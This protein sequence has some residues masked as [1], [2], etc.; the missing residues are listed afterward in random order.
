MLRDVSSLRFFRRNSGKNA[1]PE[2]DENK[3][4]NSIDPSPSSLVQEASRPPLNVIQETCQLPKSASDQE[5]THRTKIERT[6]S[7][8]KAKSSLEPHAPFTT[9]DKHG[10]SSIQGRNRFGWASKNELVNGR[11]S[12]APLEKRNEVKDEVHSNQGSAGYIEGSHGLTQLPPSNRGASSVLSTPHSTRTLGKWGSCNSSESGSTQS[13][14]AKSGS[15]ATNQGVGYRPPVGVSLRAGNAALMS[16]GLS[17]AMSSP[18]PSVINTIEVPHFELR[19]DISFWM[20]HNVQVLIRI[21]PLNSME[22]SLHGFNRCL[23]QESAQTITWIGQPETRFTFDHVACETINQEMLFRVAG[24]PMVENCMSGYNSCMFAYGQTGSGKTYTMLGD[25][26]EVDVK[27]N[28]DRGMTPRIFEFLFERTRAEEESRKNEKLRYACKCSF[29]EIYNEQITDLLEPSSTNLLLR[30]DMLKGVYVENLTEYEVNTV[31]DVL[32]LLVQGAANR[33]VAATNMNRESSRSHS[34]FTCVIESR[35]EKDSMTNYRYGRLN[36]VDLAGSERQKTSGAEG[37]RLKEAANINKSLSTLGHVIMALVDVAHGKQRHVPYR[38]S[39]LTFLLQDSLG[40][41]SKTMIIANVSPSIGCANETFSTLKFAQRAKLIQNNAVVNE[42]ASGDVTA[43]QH[44]IKLLKDE[45]AL[46]KRQNVSRSLKFGEGSD[47]FTKRLPETIHSKVDD[48]HSFVAFGSPTVSTKKLK[49]LEATLTGALRREQMA[50]N[51]TKQLEA[52]IEQLNRL[53]R[54]REEESRGSKMMLRFRE[55]K[56]RRMEMLVDE[57]IPADSYLQEENNALNE[58]IQLLRTRVDRNPEIT[59]FAMENIRLLEQLRRFQDFYQEGERDILLAEISHLRNQLL[60]ILDEKC[61]QT[62][63]CEQDKDHNSYSTSQGAVQSE[64][65][66]TAQENEL[67]HLEV[68]STLKELEDCKNRL[69]SCLE[70]NE[71]LTTEMRNMQLQL[72]ELKCT[73]SNYESEIKTLQGQSL[74]ATSGGEAADVD[75]IKTVITIEQIQDPLQGLQPLLSQEAEKHML[76]ENDGQLENKVS[77]KYSEELLNLQLELNW[78]K[79]ILEEERL[80]RACVEERASHLSNELKDAKSLAEALES[81]DILS[82]NELE[83]LREANMKYSELLQR[84][85]DEI[86]LL[87][88]QIGPSLGTKEDVPLQKLE[89]WKHVSNKDSPL[90]EKLKQMQ[91]ALEKS[92]KLNM[93]YQND[94]VSHTTHEQEMDRIRQQVEAETAEAIIC[95]QEELATLQLQV[96]TSNEKEVEANRNLVALEKEF[97]ILQGRLEMVIQENS[98]LLELVAG[99]EDDIKALNN[100]WERS[101]FELSEFLADGYG[102]LDDASNQANC[103]SDSFPKGNSRIGQEFERLVRTIVE[104]DECIEDLHK[105]LGDAHTTAHDL[106]WKLRSLRGAAMAMADAQQLETTEKEREIF[107][108]QSQL[109]EKISLVSEL[110]DQIE[111][112]KAQ[113][114]KAEVCAAV[115]FLTVNRL[116]ET[117]LVQLEHLRTKKDKIICDQ[118]TEINELRNKIIEMRLQMNLL[119]ESSFDLKNSLDSSLGHVQ[120]MELQKD[121]LLTGIDILKSELKDMELQVENAWERAFSSEAIMCLTIGANQDH[122]SGCLTKVLD[123]LQS[124]EILLTNERLGQFRMGVDN[125][126]SCMNGFLGQVENPVK[127]QTRLK[128]LNGDVVAASCGLVKSEEWTKAVLAHDNGEKALWTEEERDL[129]GRA[130]Y[131][132][133]D[134]I[135]GIYFGISAGT[136]TETTAHL[137]LNKDLCSGM[138]EVEDPSTF[139]KKMREVKDMERRSNSCPKDMAIQL[140]RQEIESA[141]GSLKEVQA[142]MSVIIH[143]NKE[144]KKSEEESSGKIKA[145]ASEILKLQAEVSC[146]EEWLQLAVSKMSHR[147]YRVQ[148]RVEESKAHWY[149]SKEVLSMELSD[150]KVNAAQK[151]DEASVLLSKFQEAQETM[152]E[153]DLMVNALMKVKETAKLE[154]QGYKERECEF[155][156]ERATLVDELQDLKS[157][158]Q[159]FEFLHEHCSLNLEEIRSVFLSVE[160]LFVQVK[161]V[162]KGK[163]QAI[164]NDISELRFGLLNS[165]NLSKSWLEDIWSEI[166]G[167]DCAVSV[168][169]LCHMGI[170]LQT[171]T[172]LNAEIGFINHGLCE[173]NSLVANLR[174]LNLKAK[175]ELETCSILRGKLL[176]DIKNSFDRIIRK[177]DE[178]GKISAKLSSFEQKILDLQ[179]Q[180]E[181]M[182]AKSNAMGSELA[183]LIKELDEHERH[184]LVEQETLKREKEEAHRKLEEQERLMTEKDEGHHKLEDDSKRLQELIQVQHDWFK[185]S[186]RK[187]LD[188]FGDDSLSEFN[189]GIKDIQGGKL[190]IACYKKL[191]ERDIEILMTELVARDIEVTYLASE[192]VEGNALSFNILTELDQV[193]KEKDCLYLQVQDS[194][195]HISKVEEEVKSVKIVLQDEKQKLQ[196][197]IE[198]KN[199]EIVKIQG[200][201]AEK[202]RELVIQNDKICTARTEFDKIKRELTEV[203][204]DRGRV[205]A[206]VR[207]LKAENT[208]IFEDLKSQHD[209]T[210]SSSIQMSVLDQKNQK[211]RDE[212]C[213]LR[214]LISGLQTDLEKKITELMELNCSNSAIAKEFAT[215]SQAMATQ[216]GIINSLKIENQRLKQELGEVKEVGERMSIEGQNFRIEHARVVESLK[217]REVEMDNLLLTKHETCESLA[218][219]RRQ[220]YEILSKLHGIDNMFS[221]LSMLTEH[222]SDT[223]EAVDALCN[224]LL[225]LEGESLSCILLEEREG[226]KF[227]LADKLLQHLCDCEETAQNF[228]EESDSLEASAKKL[229]SENLSLSAELARK[230]E[231]VQGLLFDMHLLQELASNAKDRNNEI[232]EMLQVLESTE[233]E[234]EAA[235][236]RNQMFEIQLAE[237]VDS[238]SGLEMELANTQES[239]KLVSDENLS[240]NNDIKVFLTKKQSIEAELEEK[241]KLIEGL[242]EE[243]V[244]I[245]SFLDHDK[246]LI[247][248]FKNDLAKVGSE[249]D[250][251]EAEV[252]ALKDQLEMAQALAEENEAIAAEERQI[253]EAQKAYAEEKEEEV[254]LLERSVEE[255]ERTINVLE[256][257]VEI[258]IG[259]AERQRLQRE[260]LELELQAVKHQMLNVQ[261]VDMD[262]LS[263]SREVENGMA[264]HLGKKEIKLQEAQKK[265]SILEKDIFEKEAEIDKCKAH[266]TELTLHAEAQANE[267][268]QKFKALEAMAQQVK[269]ETSTSQVMPAMSARTERSASK[270]R[271]SGSPFKCIGLGLSHQINSEKDEEL[272]AGR[273]R[274][275]ELEALAASRQKEIFMLNTRLASAESMTHD[276]IRDL[277]GVKLDMTNYVSFLDH[278]HVLEISE[279]VRCQ[280]DE[281]QEKGAEVLKLRKQLNEF[282]EERAGWLDEVN[283][284]HSEMVAARIT[285]EKL[286]QHEQYLTT[287]NE[288]LKVDNT[289]HKKKVMALELEVKKLLGQQNLQQRIHH[290]AKIKEENDN[291]KV[292]NEEIADK[293]RHTEGLLSRVS[294][295]LACYRASNG[296]SPYFDLDEEER[297][298]NKLKETE[299][300]RL[301]LAQ[302]LLCLCTSILKAAGITHPTQDINPYV[303]EDAL[304]KLKDQV[305]SAERELQDLKFKNK[306]AGERIHLSG[307]RPQ[308]SP[309]NSKPSEL[310]IS[311]PIHN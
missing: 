142:Q 192:M 299:D 79:G 302:K 164:T 98:R 280:S 266:I 145:F 305:S 182:L 229:V 293:L 37:E 7:K 132:D 93:R 298:K 234:L 91:L 62:G 206:E 26:D 154:L 64:L 204:E 86:S 25:I 107:Q 116:S 4:G 92:R 1:Q 258:I 24:L 36:L 101:T 151:A 20:D 47:S 260:E 38:D 221:S 222:C 211:L 245:N 127:R 70:V 187:E 123:K 6:P 224:R 292:Q 176:I 276:V 138:K 188:L 248:G 242:E 124:D 295:E 161:E 100:A 191:I 21:R 256:N 87:K 131:V 217:G 172:G 110:Q 77:R 257:K 183:A 251:L 278:Q 114:K 237:K 241:V 296:K 83:D 163:F 128:D 73:C 67:L 105:Q 290:H 72:Q 126:T 119:E 165:T 23:R 262:I 53:V 8:N 264:S 97:K 74:F 284:K 282:I 28:A 137:T 177:E 140:L 235:V 197:D 281:S 273:Q 232:E 102:A 113:I 304:N 250:S 212:V 69:S 159:Q 50:E 33:K 162:T 156:E 279:E 291:L 122:M 301:Q 223:F 178:T 207:I 59:R 96:D 209:E 27:S 84:Q 307:L 120:A 61:D 253:G 252:L 228:I 153:A 261:S 274:I 277:L 170:L 35:W 89:A 309:L 12:P 143:E 42:D 149:K 82:I 49:S 294:N 45:L 30:E 259:D 68:N 118:S 152:K 288:L 56:I 180:E 239:V 31:H 219:E 136:V 215:K 133:K 231:I 268:K 111:G 51:V 103:I 46:F 139:I 125:L 208:R 216:S 75:S 167:K 236:A 5:L 150:A 44:Q 271:G 196:T 300:E 80:S 267:Y 254:K 160:E 129:N 195:N 203:M 141:L 117:N 88:K 213:S 174:D 194:C 238:I 230:D 43:L 90:L 168:L 193:Q 181:S 233:D 104:K 48:L 115:S 286:R 169:H 108:L 210:E 201:L 227:R 22:R 41:N 95:L 311:S 275:E 171:V 240:L 272:S 39:R 15:K 218:A 285:L 265:I 243:I 246:L 16:K 185:K 29:L 287:E 263:I 99:K 247:E 11:K 269:P 94:Q 112:G 130:V 303:A 40:G 76:G 32:K 158:E 214:S 57:L 289:N 270:S 78:V 10:V 18:S 109:S 310:D 225:H 157:L 255:L 81:Q 9:P 106:D 60:N 220:N 226:K 205:L 63:K 134:T 55:D 13:T 71:K 189:L 200:E 52:E 85:E 190:N 175:G 148:E 297:L 34:V 54:Q 199:A 283:R 166:I 308:V 121:R 135:T 146:R 198:K 306:I 244:E 249:R 202:N 184:A 17:I 147:L 66:H 3:P 155:L 19:E 58:E 14:P 65:A 179:V 186:M 173:S 2:S 144:L